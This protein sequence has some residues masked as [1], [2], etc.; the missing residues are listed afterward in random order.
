MIKYAK[1]LCIGIALA[2]VVTP[3]GA[4]F[5]KKHA[6]HATHPELA[7]GDD[8]APPDIHVLHGTG[9]TGAYHC[10]VPLAFAYSC[11]L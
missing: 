8:Y 9:A 10:Y 7:P 3:K 11:E 4:A 2:G 5:A 6:Q 1:L